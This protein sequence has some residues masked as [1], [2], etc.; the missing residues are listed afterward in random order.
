MKALEVN[1]DGLVGPTHHY[2]GLAPGN[3]ASQTHRRQTSRPRDAALEGLRKMKRLADLGIPQAV[4]PPHER[5]DLAFLREHGFSGTD[6]EVVQS[7]LHTRPDLLS[8]A[9][10]A[11]AMW[12]ANAA[13]VSPS[14]DTRDGRVHLTPA[15]LIST[16]HRRR[17]PVFTT[18]L[19]RTIF[20]DSNHFAVHDPL[21]DDPAFADEGAA[22]HVRFCREHGEP[23]LEVFVFGRNEAGPTTQRYPARQTR[24]AGEAIAHRHG[25]SADRTMFVRQNPAAIDAGVFH[26]DVIA[27]ANETV[28]LCHAQAY[29]NQR[30]VLDE[31]A[32]RFPDLQRIEITSDEL[33]VQDAV[34]TYLFNSQLITLP[35]GEMLLLC[36][37]EC[38]DHPRARAAL[39][40]IVDH[41]GPIAGV[42]FVDVRQSM[43]NGGGPACLRLRV[44]LTEAEL[45]AV[46]QPILLT[47]QLDRRLADWIGR[48]YR[49]ELTIDSLGDPRL[50]DEVRAALDELSQILELG[51]IYPFQQ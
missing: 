11:S 41:N 13:T 44:V 35:N 33:T 12:A 1:F 50:V 40:R 8:I 16:L 14:A 19:F 42:E 27:V 22:N 6:A 28:L 4:L 29:V 23:G 9:S 36:P 32:G 17:E 45:D 31:L 3:L 18:R 20:A 5:P 49:E 38:A 25:L 21:P 47:E 30:Q 15:N 46:H 37:A 51:A 10:S 2:G 7:S 48:H 26:N 24:A 39:D 43:Q 34:S